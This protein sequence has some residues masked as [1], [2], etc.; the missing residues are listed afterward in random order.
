MAKK[1]KKALSKYGWRRGRVNLDAQV[2]GERLEELEQEQGSLTPQILVDDARKKKSI[3][4]DYFEWDDTVAAEEHRKFQARMLLGEIVVEYTDESE[5]PREIR[6]FVS[7]VENDNRHFTTL[8]RAMSDK[9]LRK[10][11][12]AD[13]LEGLRQ[14]RYKYDHLKEFSVVYEAMDK[15]KV[16]RKN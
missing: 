2:V 9:E 5:E 8:D 4:H 1:K 11:V 14:W 6:A 12:I 16:K 7:V 3:M 15:L 10:Q 13:A